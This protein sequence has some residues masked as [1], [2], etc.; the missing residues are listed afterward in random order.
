MD[1]YTGDT[2]YDTH[3][4][5]YKAP[6]TGQK[7]KSVLSID[8]RQNVADGLEDILE[9]IRV[10]MGFQIRKLRSPYISTRMLNVFLVV[11]RDTEHKKKE[12][13]AKLD[14]DLKE[15]REHWVPGR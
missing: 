5:V 10:L 13:L 7:Y 3:L 6:G 15:F 11:G 4:V 1:E 12:D 2:Y 14:Q 8:K 9:E